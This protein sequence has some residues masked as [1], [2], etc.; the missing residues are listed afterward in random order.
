ML[1][2]RSM[3][4]LKEPGHWV[5]DSGTTREIGCERDSPTLCYTMAYNNYPAC[6]IILPNRCYLCPD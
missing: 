5:L 2:P 3:E 4:Y 1:Q 6:Y